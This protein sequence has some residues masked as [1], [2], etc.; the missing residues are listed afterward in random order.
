M[1]KII[2]ILTPLL[3]LAVAYGLLRL[4]QLK[5]LVASGKATTEEVTKLISE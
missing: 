4:R 2:L 5:R 3:A 1:A